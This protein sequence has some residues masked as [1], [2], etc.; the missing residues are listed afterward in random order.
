MRFPS[1]RPRTAIHGRFP[2]QAVIGFREARVKQIASSAGRTGQGGMDAAGRVRPDAGRPGVRP[3][4]L[5]LQLAIDKEGIISSTFSNS[6]TNQTQTTEGMA[7]KT[8]PITE[9][10]ISNRTED[11]GCPLPPGWQPAYNHL[12]K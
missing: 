1:L 9:T 6:A 12:N 10:R 11:I 4:S 2:P 3:G 8:R 5:F 7:G